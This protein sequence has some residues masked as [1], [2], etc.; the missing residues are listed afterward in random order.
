[1]TPDRFDRGLFLAFPQLFISRFGLSI[2]PEANIAE[3]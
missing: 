1:M 3:A 2:D